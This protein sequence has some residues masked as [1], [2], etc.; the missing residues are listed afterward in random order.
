[1]VLRRMAGESSFQSI[2]PSPAAVALSAAIL[3]PGSFLTGVGAA[4]LTEIYAEMSRIWPAA[5]R[6][7]ERICRGLDL[8]AL[9]WTGQRFARLQPPRREELVKRWHADATP[10]GRVTLLLASVLKLFYFGRAEIHEHFGVPHDKAPEH[11]EPEPDYMQQVRAGYEL[12]DEAEELE[13]D[14][15]VVGSGA[16]GAIVAKELAERNHAVLLVEQGRYFKRHHFTGQVLQAF[17]DFYLWD[18]ENLAVGNVVIGVPTAKTVG[19]ST[20]INTATCFRPP[21]WVFRR[22]TASGLSD[23]SEER[24]APYFEEVES[25]L[26]VEPV[27]EKLW[28]RHVELMAGVAD[29]RGYSHGP[30]MR[31]A[32]DCDGQNCC[33]LGC[34]SGGKNS[35]DRAYVPMALRHGAMLLTETRLRRVLIRHRRVRGVELESGGRRFTVTARRVVLCCGTLTTPQILWDHDLGGKL[36]GRNLTIQPSL[37]VCARLAEEVF[38]FGDVVSSSHYIDEFKDDRAYLISANLPLDFAA[39][40]L[41]LVGRELIEQMEHQQ[42]FGTWGVL[43]A[44]TSKGRLRR[45][46]GGRAIISYF[47]NRSDVAHLQRYLALLCELYLEAGARALFPAIKSWPVIRDRHDLERFRGARL[48]PLD[49]LMSAY[50][51]TGTCIMGTDP[52]TSVVDPDYELRG[53]EGLSIVDG[54]VVP[55]PIGV[56]SQLTVM[57]FARRAADILHEQLEA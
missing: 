25:A 54:S 18:T 9:G 21:S 53:I 5:P 19:G 13:A 10:L 44:E 41:Q 45:L 38:G 46:P 51:P 30:M 29:A 11:P 47:L 20:T 27:P 49:L 4:E 17:R 36:V 22:W 8:V 12:A 39:M 24:M 16:A 52:A 40:A 26:Q 33:D 15:V 23:L 28:G 55:G 2:T 50:H 42:Y 37:S 31:N 56:N 43:I 6:L 48:S 14:V 3:P 1:M 32:P 34:P 57:A 35:M 7:V